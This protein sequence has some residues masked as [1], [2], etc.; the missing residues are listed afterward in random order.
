MNFLFP[1]VTD[2]IAWPPCSI[3]KKGASNF[4]RKAQIEGL[5]IDE[6]GPCSINIMRIQTLENYFN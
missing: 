2:S 6:G 1:L 5:V 4:A 3:V